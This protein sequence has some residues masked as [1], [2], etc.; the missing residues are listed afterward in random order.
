MSGRVETHAA[1]ELLD[2]EIVD[3]DGNAC[4]MVDGLEIEGAGAHAQVVALLV[5]PGAWQLRLP[6]LPRVVAR[7]L[8]GERVVRIPIEAV[9]EV[10]EVVRLKTGTVPPSPSKKG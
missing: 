3:A 7:W 4:G 1:A 9:S 5:G 6:A 2:H 10:T 8:F